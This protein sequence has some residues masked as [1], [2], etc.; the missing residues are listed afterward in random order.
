LIERALATEGTSIDQAGSQSARITA[1]TQFGYNFFR[2][3]APGFS[4]VTD[5]PVSPDYVLGPGDTVVLNLWGSLEG[6]YELEV[7]RAGEI[8]LPQAGTLRVWGLPFAR[9]PEAIR[10]SLGKLFK[11]FQLNV[12]LGRLKLIKVFVVGEV[13]SPGGYDVSSL[14]TV[15]NALTAAGGPLKTGTLRGIQV[16]RGGQVA[17]TIDLYDFFLLGDKTKD[18]R[19]QSGDAVFVPMIG[20]VAGVGGSVRRPAVY[21][22][23]GEET[24][25]DLFALAGGIVP[26]GYLQRV[27]ISRVEAFTKKVVT[28]FNLAPDAAGR[29]P[30]ELMAAVRL[31]DMDLVK[32]F[33]IDQTLR[34]YV[35]L[36]GHVLRPGDYALKPG[37]RVSALL[38]P[39]SL[40][41]EYYPEIG[42][43]T[44]LYPPDLRP[45]KLYFHLA[46]ALAGDREQDLELREFDTVRV[47]S[48]WEMEEMPKVRVSGEV[49]KPGEYRLFDKMTVRDLVLQ[50]GNPTVTA[51]LKSADITRL[52]RSGEAVTAGALTVD[53]EEALKAN[54]KENIALAPFDELIVRRIP[55]WAEETQRYVTLTGEVRFP[56][57]Y[58]VFRGDH[59][60][61]VLERAGGFTDKAYLKAAKFTRRSVQE[62]Q[63]KR[64]EE[65]ARRTEEELSKKQSELASVAASKEEL[66]A[67]RASL[68]ALSKS[69][70]RLKQAKAEGRVVI[71]LSA[72]EQFKGGPYDVELMGGDVLEIP[73][74]PH[75]V[76]VVGEVYSPT[77][78]LSLSDRDVSYYLRKAGGPTQQAEKDEIY[79]LRADGSVESRQQPA[80]DQQAGSGFLAGWFSDPFLSQRLDAGDTLVVPRRLEKIAWMREIKDIT[81]IMAQVALTAGVLIAAGL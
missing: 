72:L 65:V 38:P 52:E 60:S 17:E 3:L 81:T 75:A 27:Q 74:S 55:N 43:L 69:L 58:P 32:V 24:L 9:L 7:S 73:P 29:P 54:P 15:I 63:Q 42:E 61:S 79:I 71:R 45:R 14:S 28:D 23:K 8:V 50:A 19:L 49:K 13:Q 21:E 44:R 47:F 62:M 70:E 68:E 48:R 78:I 5:V 77:T 4:P 25:K 39:D 20:K 53:L 6:T 18:V 1:L 46:K 30:E 57:Q 51:Y 40:L 64:L 80:S 66:E 2:P 34:G 33:P 56:G 59:V 26:T 16:R 37:M 76:S 35:R 67:T 41:S 31:Q 11:D 36:E 22:L 10:S 12:N